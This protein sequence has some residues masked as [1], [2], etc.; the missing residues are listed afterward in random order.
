MKN[1]MDSAAR[2]NILVGKVPEAKNIRAR[3]RVEESIL[4]SL[5]G[6]K[7]PLKMPI[8]IEIMQND[9]GMEANKNLHQKVH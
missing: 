2:V 3:E 6:P 7:V 9:V 5:R 8:K 4:D 1:T